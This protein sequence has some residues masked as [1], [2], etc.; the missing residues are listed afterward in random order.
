MLLDIKEEFGKNATLSSKDGEA[1]ADTVTEKQ[2][3][4][5]SII[6]RSPILENME[7]TKKISNTILIPQFK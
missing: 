7:M 4:T 6:P 1:T 5:K 3:Q 2:K